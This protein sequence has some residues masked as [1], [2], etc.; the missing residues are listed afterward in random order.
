MPRID[1]LCTQVQQHAT[2]LL[3]LFDVFIKDG[4]AW[5]KTHWG[6]ADG[7]VAHEGLARLQEYADRAERMA[8]GIDH[9]AWNPEFRQGKAFIVQNDVYASRRDLY[10][11]SIHCEDANQKA[12]P[13]GH[14][15]GLWRWP[16]GLLEQK[17]VSFVHG[18]L[19]TSELFC[20][21]GRADMVP[22][23]MRQCNQL[24]LSK[25]YC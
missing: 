10:R 12:A 24:N 6:L 25:V 15:R 18:D 23:T 17:P 8:R 22:M 4:Q 20:V 11:A 9:S 14:P 5:T 1:R 3:H 7:Q 13:R 19:G 16:L 21:S 2:A